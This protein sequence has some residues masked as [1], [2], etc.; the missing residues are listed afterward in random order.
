M[1]I[2]SSVR[3]VLRR[4]GLDIVRYPGYSP[5]VMLVKMLR[6]AGVDTVVDVGA[7]GGRFG[8]EIREVGWTGRIVSFEPLSEPFS[9]LQSASA[10]DPL[11]TAHRHALGDHDETATMQIAS[12]AGESSSLLSMRDEHRSAAPGITVVGEESVEVRRLDDI[13][14]DVV[15]ADGGLF[16]KV[17]TQGFESHVLAGAER[18]VRERCVGVQLELSLVP[19]YSEGMSLQDGDDFARDHGMDTVSIFPGFTDL[20]TGRMLQVDA[21]YMRS[22]SL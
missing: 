5:P 9:R 20:A 11:W 17:D 18:L 2:V 4:R 19:M 10:D 21:V 13:A 6:A 15:P 12:N 3:K 16:L 8:E 14:T 7:N 1:P 22:G